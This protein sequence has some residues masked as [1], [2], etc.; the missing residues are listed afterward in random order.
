MAIMK[1]KV[2]NQSPIVIC[3]VD[4][5]HICQSGW[6]REVSV[7]LS[8]QMVYKFAG[9]K[10]DV[11]I[12]SDEDAL[13]KEA[14]LCN[15]THA[16][17]IASG[18]SFKL[19][20]KIF[21]AIEEK[22]NTDFALAGHILDRK[23]SYYELHHQF[24]IVRLSDYRELNCPLVGK[25]S[26][27]PHTKIEPY[28]STEN[29]HDDYVPLW[30]KQGHTV[31]QYAKLM[32]GWNLITEFL[33]RDKVIVDIGTNIR[34]VQY[35]TTGIGVNWIKNLE[36]FGFKE[37]TTVTFTDVNPNCLQFMKKMVTDWDGTDYGL[38]YKEFIEPLVPNGPIRTTD[39][40]YNLAQEQWVSFKSQFSN[41]D[42]LWNNI[43]RLK[44]NFVLINFTASYNLDW[45]DCNKS[46]FM[47]VSDLFNYTPFVFN[48]SLKYRIACENRLIESVKEKDP[49]IHLLF[50]SR[51]ASGFNGPSHYY[52][53]VSTFELTDINKLNAPPW[54]TN[55]WKSLRI[56]R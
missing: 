53:K 40:Y 11:F 1:F 17:I 56:L 25:E 31:K 15:Y 42:T 30:I 4:N 38:L 32:H 3:I 49:N 46:T 10:H 21:N 6:A 12:D 35:I 29:V 20:D 23:E 7:N 18:T 19:N 16:V 44:Y 34:D 43:K 26:D 24:Y 52:G 45:I 51:A 50:S 39:S 47:N 41:W 37:D 5:H 14:S 55:D 28:R 36:R 54:H 22:C 33:N 13:L 2:R 9:S 27:T 8:D 48:T